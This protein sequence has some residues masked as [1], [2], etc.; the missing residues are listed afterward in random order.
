MD[1]Q[2]AL[3]KRKLE[4]LAAIRKH[5]GWSEERC[6][7]ELGVTYATLSRWERGEALPRSQV[8]LNAIGAFIAVHAGGDARDTNQEEQ[9]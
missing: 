1:D 3:T 5:L 7:H 6:A 2:T 8:V 4:Q 9:R